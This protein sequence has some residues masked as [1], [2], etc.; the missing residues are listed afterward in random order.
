MPLAI[1]IKSTDETAGTII[2][3]WDEVSE[4]ETVPS[5]QSLAYPPHISIAVYET[6]EPDRLVE[7]FET[8]FDLC[9]VLPVTFD[10][11]KTFDAENLILWA[12]PR[13]CPGLARLA[14]ALHTAID[15]KLCAP[16]YRPGAWRPHCT[17]ATA[18]RPEYAGAARAFAR[19]KLEPFTVRFD[20]AD[21]VDFPPV[22]ILRGKKLGSDGSAV[23]SATGEGR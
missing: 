5:M 14:E 17:L 15:P 20:A 12:A 1:S 18:I 3:L 13:P 8:V 16:H 10:R 6:I 23:E 11:I 19:R 4:F 2:R 21:C 7:A 9:P 22:R